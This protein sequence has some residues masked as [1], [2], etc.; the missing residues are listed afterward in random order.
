[1]QTVWQTK[2]RMHRKG[3]AIWLG[4]QKR[5]TTTFSA[6]TE[7]EM[8]GIPTLSAAPPEKQTNPTDCSFPYFPWLVEDRKHPNNPTATCFKD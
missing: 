1:M 5:A 2:N 3:G 4:R 6:N 8:M 7:Q